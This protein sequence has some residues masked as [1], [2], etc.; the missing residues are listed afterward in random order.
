M[1]VI[2]QAIVIFVAFIVLGTALSKRTSH[3]GKASKKLGLI[4]LAACMVVAVLFPESTN[5]L[6]RAVGV[7]RGADLL[8]YL[9]VVAFVLYVL[10]NYLQIRD[11]RDA[12]YRLARQIAIMDAKARYR[13]KK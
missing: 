7:G 11:Q 6:A 8:L 3:G 12:T 5:M 4:I 9:T 13:D 2:I 10:N 1:T